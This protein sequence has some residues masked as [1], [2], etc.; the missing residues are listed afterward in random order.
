MAPYVEE[1]L[2]QFELEMSR[3]KS[4]QNSA[5]LGCF[6]LSVTMLYLK[7]QQMKNIPWYLLI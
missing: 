6:S 3:R 2:R 7:L 4:D 5:S 1:A